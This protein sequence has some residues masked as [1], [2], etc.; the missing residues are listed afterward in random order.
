MK[1]WTP[2]H[3]L[4]GSFLLRSLLIHLSAKHG[5]VFS[6]T[7]TALHRLSAVDHFF[8]YDDRRQAYRWLERE[9]KKFILTKIKMMFFFS[10]SSPID[11]LSISVCL[12]MLVVKKLIRS[13]LLSKQGIHFV[14][15]KFI[16]EYRPNLVHK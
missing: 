5:G 15:K 4:L 9:V 12:T 3:S 7:A 1:A 16:D 6:L 14:G 2:C 11:T 8:H 13:I 10:Q